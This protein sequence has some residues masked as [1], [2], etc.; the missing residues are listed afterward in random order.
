MVLILTIAIIVSLVEV[1]IM[2]AL[3]N[4]PIT[5]SSGVEA[6]VDAIMLTVLSTPLI[7]IYAIRPYVDKTASAIAKAE[8]TKL[9]LEERELQIAQATNLAN[10]GT[11]IWDHTIEAYEYI[12]PELTNIYGYEIEELTRLSKETGS[13]LN[14]IHPDDK[15]KV[16]QAIKES[17]ENKQE[18]KAVYR[19]VR[20]DGST[21]TVSA[22]C[23]HFYSDI[24][25]CYRSIGCMQDITSVMEAETNYRWA[26]EF[27]KMGH[28]VWNDIE[29]KC[30]YC[31]PE[32]ARMF[33]TTVD[34]FIEMSEKH[35]MNVELVHADDHEIYTQSAYNFDKDLD[36]KFKGVQGDGSIVYFHEY[37]HRIRDNDGRNIKTKG[38]LQDITEEKL[39]KE[40]LQVALA[41]AEQANQAKSEF[42]ATMSHEFRTPLNAILG[43]SEILRA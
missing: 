22:T 3:A 35:D 12:A 41:E 40:A 29:D 9:T 34:K 13:Y 30:E 33:G 6:L 4:L 25:N 23:Q 43:F 32:L 20:K 31:S 24:G 10:L 18:Y 39:A 11:W 8:A 14:C 28:Y 7:Y 21:R 26:A 19:I 2:I 1:V 27:G 15:F 38:I 42:L 5:L 37:G 17:I 16:T 36:I